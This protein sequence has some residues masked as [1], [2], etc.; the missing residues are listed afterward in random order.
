[1]GVG[2]RIN[3]GPQR[4]ASLALGVGKPS[5]CLTDAS[6]A[7]KVLGG[8]TGDDQPCRRAPA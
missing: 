1:M 2:A 6:P 3:P 4:F 7:D 5:V 8:A